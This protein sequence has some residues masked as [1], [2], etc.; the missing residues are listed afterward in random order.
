M[1]ISRQNVAK[2]LQEVDIA[3]QGQ[4]AELADAEY[5]GARREPQEFDRVLL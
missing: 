4:A 2:D 5:D 1:K 3:G